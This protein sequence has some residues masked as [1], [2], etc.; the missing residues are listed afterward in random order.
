PL[1]L[2]FLQLPAITGP[3]RKAFA[4]LSTTIL[5]DKGTPA[6]ETHSCRN[7]L[8]Q[9]GWR[10]APGCVCLGFYIRI[11]LQ[12]PGS[13]KTARGLFLLATSYNNWNAF[14]LQTNAKISHTQLTQRT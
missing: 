1:P 6:G 12:T 10:A 4:S 5:K 7:P 2:C 3:I 13:S 14:A 9:E 8:Y 11:E